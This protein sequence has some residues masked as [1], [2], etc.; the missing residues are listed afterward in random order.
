MTEN[1]FG[2]QTTNVLQTITRWLGGIFFAMTL[3]LSYLYVQQ[4]RWGGSNV[5]KKLSAPTVVPAATPAPALPSPSAPL[6]TPAATSE[7]VKVDGPALEK[8]ATPA[9][10]A[11]ANPDAP[12]PVAPAEAKP[13]PPV[14]KPADSPA[15]P[16]PASEGDAPVPDAASGGAVGP[17]ETAQ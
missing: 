6:Q 10:P 9:P 5:Q 17:K 11:T 4:T 3:L 13:E 14:D 8:D 1:L 2:A 15:A 16:K 7:P 12:A